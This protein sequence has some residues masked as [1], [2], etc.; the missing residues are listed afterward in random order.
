MG[1]EQ[2][3][4]IDELLEALIT[5]SDP[6]TE[7][8]QRHFEPFALTS[9]RLRLAPMPGMVVGRMLPAVQRQAAA[10]VADAIF[11]GQA[12]TGVQ[13]G[14]QTDVASEVVASRGAV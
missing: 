9:P 5:S 7:P 4:T 12:G 13:S 10:R 1:F 3:G 14:T 6:P 8:G 11:N 2:E